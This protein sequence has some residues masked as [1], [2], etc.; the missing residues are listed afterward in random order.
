MNRFFPTNPMESII[1]IF[2]DDD[3]IGYVTNQDIAQEIMKQVST[4]FSSQFKHNHPDA[5]VV[6]HSTN[7]KILLK[8]TIPGWIV[9][10]E[11]LH[12]IRCEKI[13]RIHRIK[14]F[15]LKLP[16]KQ[17]PFKRSIL[18]RLRNMRK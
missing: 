13:P 17:T 14:D 11:E 8:C 4:I 12:T 18:Q 6:T 2:M 1:A 7:N 9:N 3:V 5:D 10:T 16:S 15:N